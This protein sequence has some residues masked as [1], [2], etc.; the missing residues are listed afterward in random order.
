MMSSRGFALLEALIALVIVCGAVL[1]SLWWMQQSVLLQH[2]LIRQA[3]AQRFALDWM[4]RVQLNPNAIDLYAHR[5]QRL[6]EPMSTAIDCEQQFCHWQALAAWD[7]AQWRT[8]LSPALPQVQTQFELINPEL[9]LWR[10]TL[11]WPST[12]AN[13]KPDCPESTQ[14]V[15]LDFTPSQ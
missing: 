6:T 2:Q 12:N 13:A 5:W 10:I 3:S 8:S 14:C 11:A 4:A 7:T 15:W 9:S 1:T